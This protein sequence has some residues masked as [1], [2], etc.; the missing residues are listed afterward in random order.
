MKKLIIEHS[1]LICFFVFVLILVLGLGLLKWRVW[2]TYETSLPEKDPIIRQ[3]R[4]IKKA[5]GEHQ[6]VIIGIEGGKGGIFNISGLKKIEKISE[7]AEK[8]YLV[9]KGSV[10][11]L[12]RGGVVREENGMLKTGPLMR[13]SPEKPEEIEQLKKEVK[14][15]ELV[16]GRLVSKDFKAGLVV[17]DVSGKEKFR[18]KIHKWLERIKKKYEEPEKVL[19]TSIGY[20]HE[21]V[22]RG[23][24]RD[25]YLL[26]GIAFVGIIF[27]IF[28]IFGKWGA[29]FS[30]IV[31]GGAIIATLGT[32]LYFF[33]IKVLTITIPVIIIALGSSYCIHILVNY[34]RVQKEISDTLDRVVKPIFMAG[35]SSLIIPLLMFEIS[36]SPVRQFAGFMALG[37]FLV[38]V[39][40]L[41]LMPAMLNLKKPEMKIH[42]W[43][44]RAE[45]LSKVS[46]WSL[47]HKKLIF[48][49]AILL[50]FLSIFGIL[51][52]PLRS[53]LAPVE[54]FPENHRLRNTHEWLQKFQAVDY[55][56]VMVSGDI[57]NPD[58]I[59][60][61]EKFCE[62]AKNQP[63]VGN[64]FSV[65]NVVK[66]IN[67]VLAGKKEIP[68]DSKKLKNILYLY[69]MSV[70]PYEFAKL[71]DISYRHSL[72]K[73]GIRTWD[74]EVQR[75]VYL[76]LK[77]FAEKEGLKVDFGGSPIIWIA[78]NFY[79]AKG[80]WFVV[81]AGLP[82]ILLFCCIVFR[83][84]KWGVL[85]VVD[86]ILIVLVA[87]GVMSYQ[88][89][90]V[91]I[92]TVVVAV[93]TIGVGADFSLHFINRFLKEG[94]LEGVIKKVIVPV[95]VDCFSNIIAFSSCFVS[96]FSPV[97]NFAQLICLT[98]SLSWLGTFVLLPLL[99]DCFNRKR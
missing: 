79:I 36:I 41:L 74:T 67:K 18:G 66:E 78:N 49:I 5:F 95:T 69:E 22:D 34:S 13:N 6:T 99:I 61:I 55:F 16:Y 63:E 37:I 87:F 59:R 4:K 58:T 12:C 82:L 38:T 72:I 35:F 54:F 75:D 94:E 23:I 32:L 27:L 46:F 21:E 47:K 96:G 20:I 10:K 60:K 80:Q 98:M 11:S 52:V 39:F 90:R 17:F 64:V 44:W 45:K 14:E 93:L 70:S 65:V 43:V 84:L 31:M 85:S 62:F 42:S 81:K 26:T 2:N 48:A 77:S 1:R 7:E 56:K 92:A 29:V 15:S 50:I 89:I 73:I 8:F 24:E 25:V 33:P 9:E 28:L 71:I 40:S 97:R 57:L 91:N 51:K 86:L 30:A 76:K 53:G 19:I 83:S 68:K 88:G 3:D